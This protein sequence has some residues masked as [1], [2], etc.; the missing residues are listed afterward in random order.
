MIG[1]TAHLLKHQTFRLLTIT[2]V[3]VALLHLPVRA[4]TKT[5]AI[6]GEW[7]TQTKGSHVI[8]YKENGKYYGKL[9]PLEDVNSLDVKNPDPA[10]RNRKIMGL[11]LLNGL[12]F[13]G[14]NWTGGTI[15]DANQG[16]TYSCRLSLNKIDELKVRGYMGISMFGRTEIWTR[17]K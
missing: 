11:V 10:L 3:F 8:I 13:D 2:C 1:L 17:A 16:K 7:L 15:Y 4:Q 5:D 12:V 14:N 6:I 9:K